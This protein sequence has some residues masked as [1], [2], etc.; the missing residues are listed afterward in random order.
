M[1]PPN[2]IVVSSTN[3]IDPNIFET[4]DKSFTNKINNKGLRID[5]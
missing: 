5:T 1:C 4:F 3:K 2:N